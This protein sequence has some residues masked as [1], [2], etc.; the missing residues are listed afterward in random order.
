MMTDVKGWPAWRER[1]QCCEVA[2]IV[3]TGCRPVSKQMCER[4]MITGNSWAP[5]V[6]VPES[7]L[8]SDQE[9]SGAAACI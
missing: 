2:G 1:D 9:S 4:R 8:P 7:Q 5:K 6:F 3:R